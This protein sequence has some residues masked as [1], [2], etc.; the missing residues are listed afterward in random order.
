MRYRT[1]ARILSAMLALCLLCSLV[2]CNKARPIRSSKEELTPVG[3]V[4]GHEVLYEEL[5]Y[6]TLKYR[7][8][9]AATYGETIWDTAESRE[10]YRAELEKAVMD[11][12]TSNYAV[13][14]LCDEV[15]IKHT[16]KAIEEAVQKYVQETVDQLGG[17]KVYREQMESE[18]LTDHFFRFSLAVSFCE[19][20]LMYVYTDDL[21][22][23]ERDEDKIYDMIMGGDF[24]RT[25]HIYIENNPGDDVEKNR[26]LAQDIRRQ[27]DEGEKFNTLIGR[28]SED[29]YM[30]TTNGYYFTH[31]EMVKEYEDAA[32]ALEI[33]AISD[34]IETTDG[35]YIIQR[36]EPQTEYV[37]S[38]L[39]TLIDQYQYAMLY[40]M[41]DEKQAELSLI[42]NDYGKTLDLTTLK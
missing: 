12:I 38:N 39:S 20:E 7:E 35:F 40:N 13:L 42:W 36:L 32:F 30:T 4:A 18:F 26:A 25:L 27:I 29:F 19:T 2:S 3:T 21:G 5:R 10:L 37:L 33:G 9:M 28:H 11:N 1:P 23:I 6:L 34:V 41:I 15:Q 8:A 31:G 24:A 22:L 16:E 17:M 14:A